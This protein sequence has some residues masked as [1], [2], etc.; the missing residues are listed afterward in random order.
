[1]KVQSNLKQ[2]TSLNY[3][4]ASRKTPKKDRTFSYAAAVTAS[5]SLPLVLWKQKDATGTNIQLG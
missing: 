4:L 1:M 3:F 5:T 2:N